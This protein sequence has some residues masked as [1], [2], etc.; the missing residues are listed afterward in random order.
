[1]LLYVT[2]ATAC[3]ASANSRRSTTASALPANG[4]EVCILPAATENVFTGRHD[5]V[6]RVRMADPYRFRRSPAPVPAAGGTADG[7]RRST[8]PAGSTFNAVI[9]IT[10]RARPASL[11]AVEAAREEVGI[12]VDGTGALSAGTATRADGRRRAAVERGRP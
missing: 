9:T 1:M 2:A 11:F 4:G 3:T 5:I 12:L 6:I 10:G 8:G 7:P